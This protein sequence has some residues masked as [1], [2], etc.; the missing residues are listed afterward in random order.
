MWRVALRRQGTRDGGVFLLARF[1]CKRLACP[2]ADLATSAGTSG[3]ASLP[4]LLAGAREATRSLDCCMLDH[5][6]PP[7]HNWTHGRSRG[8]LVV[9]CGRGQFELRAYVSRTH[10]P[11]YRGGQIILCGISRTQ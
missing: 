7:L 5:G 2:G 8:H 6:P 4:G 9:A 1:T 3:L 11:D 10:R